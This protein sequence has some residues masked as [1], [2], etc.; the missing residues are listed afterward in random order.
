LRHAVAVAFPGTVVRMIASFDGDE[1]EL[2]TV[3]RGLIR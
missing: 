3:I 1:S 2:V